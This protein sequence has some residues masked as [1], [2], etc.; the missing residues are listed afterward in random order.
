MVDSVTS[1]NPSLF[2]FLSCCLIKPQDFIA[3]QQEE[4][5]RLKLKDMLAAQILH[6]KALADQNRELALI[7]TLQL[8]EESAFDSTSI[9]L[10]VG[11]HAIRRS[12]SKIVDKIKK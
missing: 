9:E 5:L 8:E 1:S 2:K 11:S 3:Q 6:Q 4:I 10:A 7:K 12:N